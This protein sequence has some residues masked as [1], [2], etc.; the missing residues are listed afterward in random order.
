MIT[1]RINGKTV[2]RKE[3][4]A[5]EAAG[6]DFNGACPMGTVAYSES[7]PLISEGLGCM[8]NQIP[9][10]RETI[11]KH[12]IKGVRVRE[13]G[14]LEITSR[15]GRAELCRVRGLVDGDGGFGDG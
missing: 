2:S 3:W 15:R 10:M 6:L 7:A 8:K 14:S 13:N 4:D 5:R 1:W 12:N 11:R 9:E